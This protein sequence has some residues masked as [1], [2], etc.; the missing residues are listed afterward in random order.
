VKRHV[1]VAESRCGRADDHRDDRRSGEHRFLEAAIE[2]ERATGGREETIASARVQL[3]IRLPRIAAGSV[4][5]CAGVVM[6]V[7]PGPGWLMIAFGLSVLARDVAWVERTLDRVR[8]RLPTDGDGKINRPT[9]TTTIVVTLAATAGALW[10][11]TR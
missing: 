1:D 4:L 9:I 11:V 3:A 8:G 5:V 6:L 2:A 10:W 7:S